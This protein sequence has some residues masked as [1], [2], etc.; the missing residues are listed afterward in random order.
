[1]SSMVG[2][3]VEIDFPKMRGERGERERESIREQTSKCPGLPSLNPWTLFI[4]EVEMDVYI[5]LYWWGEILQ[6]I[7]QIFITR[8]LEDVIKSL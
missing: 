6:V 2:A 3:N 5:L 7:P 1:M 4:W 8:S